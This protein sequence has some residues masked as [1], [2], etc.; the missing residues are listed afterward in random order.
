MD[1]DDRNEAKRFIILIDTL[2]DNAVK[3][4]ASAAAEPEALYR[5]ERWFRGAGVQAHRVAPDR[6]AL[7]RLPR[8]AARPG[9]FAHECWNRGDRGDLAA[10]VHQFQM[11][12]AR[13]LS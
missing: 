1:F 5:G 3:L 13:T 2:Y 11:D 8:A 9:G 12:P 6:D 10:C 4:V 7:G